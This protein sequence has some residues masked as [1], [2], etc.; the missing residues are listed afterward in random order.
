MAAIIGI[1]VTTAPARAADEGWQEKLR[2]VAYAR[3]AISGALAVATMGPAMAPP[4]VRLSDDLIPS[5]RCTIHV[6]LPYQ[7]VWMLDAQ[8]MLVVALVSSRYAQV[9]STKQVIRNA[10]IVSGHTYSCHHYFL[11]HCSCAQ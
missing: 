7:T 3:L 6:F 8:K 5:R 11:K 4:Q 10:C 2:T 9:R 1:L